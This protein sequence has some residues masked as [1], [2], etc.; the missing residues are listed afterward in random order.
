ML[1]IDYPMKQEQYFYDPEK[2]SIEILKIRFST[3]IYCQ[4][5]KNSLH[6]LLLSRIYLQKIQHNL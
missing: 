6:K 1:L 2:L 3:Q 4:R 5:N